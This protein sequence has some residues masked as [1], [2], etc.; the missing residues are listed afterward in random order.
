[1]LRDYFLVIFCVVKMVYFIGIIG[2]FLSGFF[3]GGGGLLLLPSLRYFMKMDEM[4]ARGTTLVT[5]FVAILIS[6]II[7]GCNQNI[8]FSIAIWIA[9][10]GAVGGFMGAKLAFKISPQWLRL[11]FDFFLIYTAFKLFFI[12]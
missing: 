1:M 5:V 4:K 3:G 9:L 12:S 2:G 11:L 10:G 6:T 7:Y 8:D